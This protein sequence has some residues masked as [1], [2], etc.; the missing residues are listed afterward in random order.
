M[1]R[2]TLTI[3]L[4]S[5]LATLAADGKTST[6]ASAESIA[7]RRRSEARQLAPRLRP[8]VV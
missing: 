1:C 3:T 5:C 6:L 8:S 4:L 7:T 2:A